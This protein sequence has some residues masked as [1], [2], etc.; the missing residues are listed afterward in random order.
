MLDSKRALPSYP[1]GVL[2]VYTPKDRKTDF[3]ARRNIERIEDMEFVCSL[4]FNVQTI[5]EQDYEFAE[6]SS[7]KLSLKVRT[8][9]FDLVKSDCLALIGTTLFDVSHT[10]KAQRE[11]YLY[12]EE[13]R[14]IDLGRDST[15]V[16]EDRR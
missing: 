10:D 13:V 11:M 2:K 8:P 5:R 7:F 16:D 6:R 3:G 14:D 9:R 12:L 15:G 1:D 4:C